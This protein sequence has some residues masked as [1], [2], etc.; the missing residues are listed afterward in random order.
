MI[1]RDL[2]RHEPRVPPS[3]SP[4]SSFFPTAEQLEKEGER[5]VVAADEAGELAG[6][7]RF[8]D[9]AVGPEDLSIADVSELLS[10]YRATA[11]RCEALARAADARARAWREAEEGIEEEERGR[12][13]ATAATAGTAAGDTFVPSPPWVPSSSAAAAEDGGGVAAAAYAASDAAVAPPEAELDLSALSLSQSSSPAAPLPPP[14]QPPPPSAAS[15]QLDVAHLLTSSSTTA[16]TPRVA[17]V[18]DAV[19]INGSGNSASLI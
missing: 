13:A 12:G 9:A 18:V 2:P 8:L 1:P 5:L 10:S 15:P 11:L 17:E 19:N 7:D 16:T 4:S 3:P 14:Q 6:G